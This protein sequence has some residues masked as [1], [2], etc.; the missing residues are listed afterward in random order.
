VGP[1]GVGCPCAAFAVLLN[2]RNQ[3][4]ATYITHLA[5]SEA[6]D[7]GLIEIA[8]GIVRSLEVFTHDFIQILVRQGFYTGIGNVFLE[9]VLSSL[10]SGLLELHGGVGVKGDDLSF[11]ESLSAYNP[12]LGATLVDAQVKTSAIIEPL[13]FVCC[14]GSANFRFGQF[15]HQIHPWIHLCVELGQ[16]IANSVE[17]YNTFKTYTYDKF[18]ND[19]SAICVHGQHMQ[20]TNSPGCV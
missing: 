20:V 15:A 10:E 18:I 1:Q 2:Q 16:T 5:V 9:L 17:P 14:L 19:F 4:P 3:I 11:A 8:L 7:N 6:R 12:N 13:V